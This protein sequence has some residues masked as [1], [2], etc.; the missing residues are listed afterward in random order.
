MKKKELYRLPTFG[1]MEYR[2]LVFQGFGL[3]LLFLGIVSWFFTQHFAHQLGY[4]PDLGDPW[5]QHPAQ[6]GRY[7][8]LMAAGSCVTAIA[9]LF[10][11]SVRRAVVPLACISF[12]S[13]ALAVGPLYTPRPHPALDLAIP[14][15]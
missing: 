10:L 15:E 11:R 12:V 5:I 13:G 8:L 4:H 14:R 3:Y 1:R 2:G 7:L 9:V 6:A